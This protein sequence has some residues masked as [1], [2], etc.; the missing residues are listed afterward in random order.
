GNFMM[1]PH[2]MKYMRSEYFQTNGVSDQ[3]SREKWE[4]DGA[5]DA[6]ERARRL[7]RKILAQ[8][9]AE[10]IPEAVDQ[11]IREQFEILL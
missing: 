2:T 11:Q 7:A 9:P 5:L 4:K 3:K 1:S 8:P 6:R 10:Y